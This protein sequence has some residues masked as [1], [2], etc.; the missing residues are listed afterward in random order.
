MW[1]QNN[2]LFGCKKGM[3]L[4]ELLT[5]FFVLSLL[6]TALFSMLTTSQ[7]IWYA[8]LT[9]S[10]GRQDIQTASWR[11]ARELRNS[12]TASIINC[13]IT[14]PACPSLSPVA[15]VFPSAYDNNGQFITNPTDG[16]AVWQKN[17]VYC[18]PQGSTQLQR[19]EESLSASLSQ[20]LNNCVN[21]GR[22]IATSISFL[23][24]TT[25]PANSSAA[26]SLTSRSANSSGKTD[27]QTNN[28]IIFLRN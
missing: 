16:T 12:N 6:S 11:I 24:L 2:N 28:V 23:R 5:I 9:H 18:V 17:V 19:K 1:H 13:T 15:F 8:S 22:L 10:S 3:S 25:N 20:Q 21:Q 14:N 27:E 4:V 26:L 7:S